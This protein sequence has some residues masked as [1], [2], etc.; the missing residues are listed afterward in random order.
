MFKNK[1]MNNRQHI[2]NEF[3]RHL[4]HCLIK[5][6]KKTPS[7]NFLAN[8]FNLRA[9]GTSTITPETA[10]KWM[11]GIAVPEI[12]RLIVLIHWLEFHPAQIFGFEGELNNRSEVDEL[13]KLIEHQVNHINKLITEY[14]NPNPSS[15]SKNLTTSK[16]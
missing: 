5:K 14:K 12:D 10:R 13:I 2:A 15:V 1:F 7:A 3:S 9:N 4:N 6:Y 16:L 11:R 8:Q